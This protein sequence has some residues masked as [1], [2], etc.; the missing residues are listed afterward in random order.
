M[1][2]RE[3]QLESRR[4]ELHDLVRKKEAEYRGLQD[5]IDTVQGDITARTEELD[6]LNI[7]LQLTKEELEEKNNVVKSVKLKIKSQSLR[8]NKIR[9]PEE[10]AAQQLGKV[11]ILLEQQIDIEK[12]NQ[13]T[14]TKGN[15]NSSSK[16]SRV[17]GQNNDLNSTKDN[18]LDDE[19]DEDEYD[20]Y[21]ENIV[22]IEMKSL[23]NGNSSGS[24][25]PTKVMVDF[26]GS[27]CVFGLT[28]S[29]TFESLLTEA[30]RYYGL[31]FDDC[32]IT[33]KR[34]IVWPADG[35][36]QYELG[37]L[38]K[39]PILRLALKPSIEGN[40]TRDH[41]KGQSSDEEETKNGEETITAEEKRLADY[42]WSYEHPGP[43]KIAYELITFLCTVL[44]FILVSQERRNVANMNTMVT[45]FKTAFVN[46]RFGEFGE[47]VYN[48]II[49]QNDFW[50]WFTGP[51]QTGLFNEEGFV[52]TYGKPVGAIEIAQ[53]RVTNT[54]CSL[55]SSI[56]YKGPLPYTGYLVDACFT[57]FGT[58]EEVQNTFPF[59][60]AAENWTECS[61]LNEKK[62]KVKTIGCEE[63]YYCTNKTC[64]ACPDASL[65]YPQCKCPT[66]RAN[67]GYPNCLCPLSGQTY[68]CSGW[69]EV[70]KENFCCYNGFMFR[71]RLKGQLPVSVQGELS[72][73]PI[74][75]FKATLGPD[76]FGF[77]ETLDLL[78]SNNW[79]DRYTRAVLVQFIIYNPNYHLY[80][81]CQFLL[82]IDRSGIFNPFP[83]RFSILDLNV[84]D[85]YDRGTLFILE[86]I[87]WVFM[88]NYVMKSI[89]ADMFLVWRGYRSLIP[90]F[91]R[92]WNIVDLLVF[93]TIGMT[94]LIR[95]L[96]LFDSNRRNFNPFSNSYTDFTFTVFINELAYQLDAVVV[97][98]MF[99]KMN[100]F[101]SLHSKMGILWK[102]LS[103]SVGM[104]YGFIFMYTLL[105]M[106]FVLMA[107]IVFG[108][109]L[110]E[111][112]TISNSLGTL[113]MVVFGAINFDD[114][115]SI[116]PI[117][118]T[119][120]F[121]IYTVLMFLILVNVFVAILSEAY[122][123]ESANVHT[124]KKSRKIQAKQSA[125]DIYRIAVLRAKGKMAERKIQKNKKLKKIEKEKE[126]Q[127]LRKK[128][129]DEHMA[130]K[131][132]QRD[133][134]E[135]QKAEE[136]KKRR[137]EQMK[138][139]RELALSNPNAGKK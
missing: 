89:Y 2:A 84:F 106:A 90:F 124:G 107:N 33:D 29:T 136:A 27:R 19:D 31:D 7:R 60:P 16:R 74:E 95:V 44:I 120:L 128:K 35:I 54:S 119:I 56:K 98:L 122:G 57:D 53:Y 41:V 13:Q 14:L 110:E 86:I 28:V 127:E 77:N 32:Y 5:N 63:G 73:Y 130:K 131:Q 68:P 30:S 87:L 125:M 47:N 116:S 55:S 121:V 114:P 81:V 4:K 123:T 105:L 25:P 49:K 69:G 34:M 138:A 129:I 113:L 100:K 37:K 10:V 126:L 1:A 66:A 99:F 70:V 92:L 15:A 40:I 52:M 111:F 46:K 102:T 71:P 109:H 82:E 61:Y 118:A 64:T 21:D 104:L 117:W 65:L 139:D 108:P 76:S 48:D 9:S 11:L 22:G 103:R 135:R 93:F 134:I 20:G 39:V 80:A 23:K 24:A 72:S 88:G 42:R 50:D 18:S 8:S 83:P 6:N 36:V 58:S 137:K 112:S 96:Y 38:S 45:S 43:R 133:E 67:E 115:Y 132:A 62:K 91:K 101:F 85:W 94:Y 79:I 12:M 3:E 97:F 17:G 51:L 59:G 78:Q 26:E 75:S